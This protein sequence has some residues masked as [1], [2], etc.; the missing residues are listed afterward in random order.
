[1]TSTRSWR[2]AALLA[3]PVAAL[4][5]AGCSSSGPDSGA[6][7]AG[8][9]ADADAQNFHAWSVKYASCMQDEGID[10]PDPSPDPNAAGLALNIDELG[11]IEAFTE[12]DETCR[13]KI[14]DPPAPLGEDGQPMSDE[15]LREQALEFTRC[16]REQ[17]VEVADPG[18]DGGI[19]I[20]ESMSQEALEACGISG[21]RTSADTDAG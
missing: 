2:R 13:G 19:T 10:Y 1:M 9:G 11:G 5:L 17:G 16:M 7:T 12:A 20:D 3:I 14:G 8:S 15:Q 6:D 18:A 21:T 4:L